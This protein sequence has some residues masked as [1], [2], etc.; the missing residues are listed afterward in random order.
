[1]IIVMKRDG[2]LVPFNRILIFV[3]AIWG[4]RLTRFSSHL[5]VCDFSKKWHFQNKQKIFCLLVVKFF[6]YETIFQNCRKVKEI[7]EIELVDFLLQAMGGRGDIF[8]KNK[9]K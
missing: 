4:L 8:G 9:L 1:M 5:M 7:K 6:Y 3:V 2:I